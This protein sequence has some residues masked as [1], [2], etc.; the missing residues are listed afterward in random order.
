MTISF[1]AMTLGAVLNRAAVD[2]VPTFDTRPSCAGAA[3][4]I[5]VTR[6]VERRQQS[7]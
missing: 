7:E 2:H 4:E 1:A 5:S 3:S 6:T